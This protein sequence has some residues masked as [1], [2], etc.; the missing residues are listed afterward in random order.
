[1]QQPQQVESLACQASIVT[2]PR[3][4]FSV[5]LSGAGWAGST[6]AVRTSGS[7][8]TSSASRGTPR[9]DSSC[10]AKAVCGMVA[11][12]GVTFSSWLG[13][14]GRDNGPHALSSRLWHRQDF[15]CGLLQGEHVPD[16]CAQARCGQRAPGRHRRR[17]R[18][19]GPRELTHGRRAALE[20]RRDLP[21]WHGVPLGSAGSSLC[22]R[23]VFSSPE[24]I[25][26]GVEGRTTGFRIRRGN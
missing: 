10:N 20:G 18:H 24:H 16:G 13:P 26:F 19:A 25:E 1:M 8:N 9:N 4:D 2:V 5:A 21:I 6:R 3:G 15:R 22:W 7:F 14:H 12:G 17:C 23:E 11:D